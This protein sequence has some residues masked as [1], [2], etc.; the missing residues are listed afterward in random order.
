MNWAQFGGLVSHMCLTDAVLASSSLTQ[1]VAGSSPFSLV[2]NN[3]LN[4]LKTYRK[5]RMFIAGV[6][7]NKRD[8]R[9]LDFMTS[10]MKVA[11]NV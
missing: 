6:L 9:L 3:S 8:N 4:S 5:S 2:T 1:E 11:C 7:F 10:F